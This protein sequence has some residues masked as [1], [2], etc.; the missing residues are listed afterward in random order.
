MSLGVS[1]DVIE[2]MG[3]KLEGH[4]ING[5]MWQYLLISYQVL[6]RR[7]NNKT[8]SSP[9]AIDFFFFSLPPKDSSGPPDKVRQLFI[10]GKST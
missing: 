3:H 9:Q 2:I 6:G 4:Y 7:R 1:V 5:Q 8:K 10:S